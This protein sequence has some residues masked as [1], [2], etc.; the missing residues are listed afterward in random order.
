MPGMRESKATFVFGQMNEPPGAR[1][2]VA[3]SGYLLL[4]ISV[5]EQEQI[6]GKMYYFLDNIFRFTQSSEVSALF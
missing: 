3:L 4:S 1:A 5:M 6:K 2:R